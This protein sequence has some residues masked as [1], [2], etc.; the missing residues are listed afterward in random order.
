MFRRK[1][2]QPPVPSDQLVLRRSVQVADVLRF[3]NGGPLVTIP[4]GT[5]ISSIEQQYVD[6]LC[7]KHFTRTPRTPDSTPTTTPDDSTSE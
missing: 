1:S 4:R 3:P 6:Q 5:P 2:H 7:D